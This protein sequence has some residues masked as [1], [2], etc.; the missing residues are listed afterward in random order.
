MSR[1]FVN[2]VSAKTGGGASILTN[3]LSLA[4]SDNGDDEYFVLTPSA[5]AYERYASARVKIVDVPSLFKR[6]LMFPILQAV[7]IPKLIREL[8][9][10]R[11][12]NLA[13]VPIPTAVRQ[14]YLFDWAYAIY[15]KSEAWKRMGLKDWL[16]RRTKLFFLRHYSR[17]PAVTVAQTQTARDRLVQQF[18]P[19]KVVVI[20][21]AVSLDH[22]NGG[23]AKDFFFSTNRIKLLC[24][25]HYYTHKNLEIFLSLGEKIKQQALPYLIITTIGENHNLGARK[26]LGAARSLGLEDVIQNIGPIS[27]TDVPSLYAQCD[28]LLLPTLLESFSG[29]YAEAMFHCKPILTSDFD[30]ARDI[31][32]DDAYYFDPLNPSSILDAIQEMLADPEACRMRTLRAAQRLKEMPGWAD[33]F[34]ML[35]RAM[36]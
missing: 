18:N 22:L 3:Y 28:A 36:G 14:C 1:I 34:R 13:D 35:R 24:L 8:A 25:S 15:P 27:M 9:C 11:V 31:C 21:N 2:A 23:E 5:S 6:S 7:V 4:V 30:F 33:V 17:Y 32:E 26:F 29:T 16:V 20:P 12:L 10:D 19:S